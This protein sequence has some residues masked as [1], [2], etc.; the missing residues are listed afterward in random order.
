MKLRRILALILAVICLVSGLVMAYRVF[1]RFREHII[2]HQEEKL[3]NVADSV[4][5]ST[6]GFLQIYRNTLEYVT[7]RR[8]FVAAETLWSETG[9]TEELLFRMEENLL[10]QDMQIKTLLAID[11]TGILLSTDGNYQYKLSEKCE[12]IFLCNDAQGKPCLA[13]VHK[14]QALCY[15][16]VIEL[17]VICDFLENSCA[18]GGED[19]MLLIDQ[20]CDLAVWHQAGDTTAQFITEEVIRNSPILSTAN[21]AVKQEF[22]K[23]SLYT[24]N[25]GDK[26]RTVGYALIGDGGSRNGFFTICVM[27][28][29]DE[30]L[31]A[32]KR[33]SVVLLI[34]LGG[35][36]LGIV[37]LLQQLSAISQENRKAV[38]EL[39]RLQEQEIVLEKINEQTQKLAHHQRLET[40]G[41]MTSS[42]SHEFN[43]LLTPIMSYSLLTMEKLPAEEEE[44]YDNLLE[45]YNASQKAKT[46]ISRL[47]DL[48]RKNSPKTFREVSVDGL[49]AKALDI[50][51]PTKPEQIEVKLDLNCEGVLIRANEIQITQMLLNLILNAFQAM[52]ECGVLQID[53]A[54]NESY[55]QISVTDNGSGIPQE[56]RQ[57]IFDPFFTTKESGKGTGLGLAI[58]AQV[59]ED[60]KGTI[61]VSDAEENGTRFC[62]RIPLYQEIE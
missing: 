11:D 28:P 52:G 61:E 13:I 6:V 49:V 40:I 47:S 15:A 59:V 33:E 7:G 42:I 31:D 45:I 46:I 4:D 58:V 19:R 48:S 21:Q 37:F 29:Y 8:G 12:E 60:H 25:E 18:F 20:N 3:S 10:N 62:V 41:T 5:R 2:S 39:A 44:L 34:S 22:R 50:A 56:I 36:L 55:V 17:D 51:L 43:N 32:L 57:K 38:K 35:I 27:T 9:E 23:V 26:N 14:R 16:A 53:T 54:L 30:H 1:A 24:Q